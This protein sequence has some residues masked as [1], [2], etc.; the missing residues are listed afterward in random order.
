M[1]RS[2]D[3]WCEDSSN[4]NGGRSMYFLLDK[5]RTSSEKT[6]G[7][8][9]LSIKTSKT[10][11]RLDNDLGEKS[12]ISSNSIN[13]FL[14]ERPSES[15]E[16]CIWSIID[17]YPASQSRYRDSL[18]NFRL[19]EPVHV[20]T[21]R[22]WG[23]V[24]E[25]RILGLRQLCGDQSV[26]SVTP[27]KEG[28]FNKNTH[29]FNSNKTTNASM[30]QLSDDSGLQYE[31]YEQ[32]EQY[33]LPELLFSLKDKYSFH[34]E[35]NKN[36]LY[37]DEIKRF[38]KLYCIT[39]FCLVLSCDDSIFWLK[40]P[41]GVIYIWSRIDSMMMRAGCDMKE[42]LLNFL[43]HGENFFYVEDYTLK[44]I[45]VIKLKEEANKWYEENK[46]TI[47]EIV[48]FDELLKPLEEKKEESNK[49]GKRKKRQRRKNKH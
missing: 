28:S 4:L 38:A 18:T 37:D 29:N 25:S 13:S 41:D 39:N 45:P 36:I 6:R 7:T 34:D 23:S 32:Y 26:V 31:Q 24:K 35:T 46:D 15:K 19:K 3:R 30:P 33:D 43:F 22:E 14:E 16:D 10:T 9:K 27:V 40:D 48:V 5:P 21:G 12:H 2:G 49:G 47:T 20:S 17:R 44:L 42:A 1:Y 8:N 11:V